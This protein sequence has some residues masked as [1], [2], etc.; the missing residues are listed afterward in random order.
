M[1]PSHYP[2]LCSKL[3]YSW[4]RSRN[5]ICLVTCSFLLFFYHLMTKP[6]NQIATIPLP[7]SATLK[8]GKKIQIRLLVLQMVWSN[9]VTNIC[10][11][12][13]PCCQLKA[14]HRN[15]RCNKFS[16]SIMELELQLT[17]AREHTFQ[18]PRDVNMRIVGFTNFNYKYKN[19]HLVYPM[20]NPSDAQTKIFW[21]I[22]VK[23]MAADTLVP[24]VTK[25]SGAMV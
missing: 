19:I 20:F 15:N 4:V 10:C 3:K 11:I 7:D 16:H 12:C 5:C 2:I 24:R 21:K 25:S 9:A 6:G 8:P 13:Q 18:L 1:T 23:L 14:R 22:H 17:Q